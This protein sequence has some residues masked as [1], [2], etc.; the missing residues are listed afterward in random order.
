LTSV[1]D[2]GDARLRVEAV[3]DENAAWITIHGEADIANVDQLEAALDSIPLDG[4][5]TVKL[6]VSDLTFVDVAA[7]R[8]L[9]TFTRRMK[10]SG[11]TVMTCGARPTLQ[12]MALELDVQDELGLPRPGP[13]NP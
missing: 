8:Q 5:K 2:P 10:Q 3:H 1:A 6:Q 4:A 13:S 9:T 11:R 12:R 7:L